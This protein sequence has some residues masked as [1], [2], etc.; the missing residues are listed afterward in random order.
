MLQGALLTVIEME[1]KITYD[2][3]KRQLHNNDGYII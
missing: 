2:K 3:Y 1:M